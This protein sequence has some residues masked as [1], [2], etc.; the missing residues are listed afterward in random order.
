MILMVDEPITETLDPQTYEAKKKRLDELLNKIHEMRSNKLLTYERISGACNT[1]EEE[2]KTLDQKTDDIIKKLE[3]GKM[4]TNIAYVILKAVETKKK[5]MDG[6][7]QALKEQKSILMF[8]VREEGKIQL[9][10]ANL[11]LGE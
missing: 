6:I 11:E 8:L 1:L 10:I 7:K 9:E 4:E 3:D 5:V 2:G